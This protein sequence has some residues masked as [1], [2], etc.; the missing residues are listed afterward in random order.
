MILFKQLV[1][2]F[3]DIFRESNDINEKNLIGF[4][5]FGVMVLFAFVTL[6]AGLFGKHIVVNDIIY[7]SFVTVV[8]GAFVASSVP[9]IAGKLS[10]YVK[11]GKTEETDEQP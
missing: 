5:A 7:D 1:M 10:R 9:E 3:T 4:L 6:I 2:K 11:K 8:I